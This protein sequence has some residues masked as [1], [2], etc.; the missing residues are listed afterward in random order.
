[1]GKFGKRL[2]ELSACIDR[3]QVTPGSYRKSVSCEETLVWD[4]ED[5]NLLENLILR[6][7]AAIGKELRVLGVRAKTINLRI[8][9]IDFQQVSRSVTILKPTQSSE[10]IFIEAKKTAKKI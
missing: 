1:M 8:K 4:T 10:I 3:S 5:E 7:S 9:H 6:F 2:T